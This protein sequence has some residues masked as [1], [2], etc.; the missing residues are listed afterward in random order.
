MLTVA[1]KNVGGNDGVPATQRS[2]RASKQ[3]YVRILEVGHEVA[4]GPEAVPDR[5]VDEPE[6]VDLEPLCGGRVDAVAR[7]AARGEVHRVRARQLRA[8]QPH[9][10]T[11]GTKGTHMRP[12]RVGRADRRAGGDRDRLLARAGR[13]VV[14]AVQRPVRPSA[15]V[16]HADRRGTYESDALWIGL[17]DEY[18]RSALTWPDALLNGC[19]PAYLV[20]PTEM[21][22][23]P[24]CAAAESAS[25]S[26][27]TSAARYF[28]FGRWGKDAARRWPAPDGAE[29]PYM[30]VEGGIVAAASS[31]E[32]S[33]R[34]ECVVSSSEG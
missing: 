28:I 11:D 30:S 7:A 21:P 16:A 24:P 6:L 23:T 19:Q 17:Y 4:I 12:L 18:G 22:V 8:R 2:A 29:L 31:R 32:S 5:A 9:A 3:E 10:H 15:A 13:A 33:A 20:L 1:R 25:E 34:I 14:V 27:E 26:V